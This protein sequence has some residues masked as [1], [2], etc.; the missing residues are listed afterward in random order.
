MTEI[1][2]CDLGINYW[3]KKWGLILED[4]EGK[5]IKQAI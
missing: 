4:L 5:L 3:N 2:P 1:C